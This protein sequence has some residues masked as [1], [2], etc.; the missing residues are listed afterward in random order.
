MY[1]E[2]FWHVLLILAEQERWARVKFGVL[3]KEN[4]PTPVGSSRH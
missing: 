2:S 3:K 1:K 4:T